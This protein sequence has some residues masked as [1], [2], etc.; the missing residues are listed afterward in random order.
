[1]LSEACRYDPPVA[2]GKVRQDAEQVRV[3]R[4]IVNQQE[5]PIFIRLRQNRLDGF[6]E[7]FHRRIE[8]GREDADQWP[9][10]ERARLIAHPLQILRACAVLL[11]PV[12]VFG[13][14][15]P[16]VL[17]KKFSP[18]FFRE[19]GRETIRREQY[20]TN[21]ALRGLAQPSPFLS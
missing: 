15:A 2:P 17:S 6:F 18:D 21:P 10:S 7:P 14:W 4:S 11:E 8:H 3:G 16:S 1:M 9:R 19:C 13:C 20:L 5:L 12:L